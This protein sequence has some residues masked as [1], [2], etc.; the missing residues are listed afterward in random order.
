MQGVK[1]GEAEVGFSDVLDVQPPLGVP[2]VLTEG[3][4]GALSDEL[5]VHGELKLPSDRDVSDALGVPEH[6]DSLVDGLVA[7]AILIWSRMSHCSLSCPM[8]SIFSAVLFRSL[9][10][11][12]SLPKCLRTLATVE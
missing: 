12:T 5:G 6:S 1:P 7:C 2:G 10:L 4:P 11:L 9:F 8:Y 3:L